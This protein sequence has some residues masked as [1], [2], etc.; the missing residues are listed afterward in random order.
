VYLGNNTSSVLYREVRSLLESAKVSAG[1]G[2]YAAAIV[3]S[4]VGHNLFLYDA[5][6]GLDDSGAFVQ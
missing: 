2:P 5:M 4:C 1:T 3:G 6:P